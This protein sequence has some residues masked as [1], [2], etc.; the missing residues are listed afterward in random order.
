MNRAKFI[1]ILHEIENEL[2]ACYGFVKELSAIDCLNLSIEAETLAQAGQNR[3]TTLVY[4]DPAHDELQLGLYFQNDIMENLTLNNPTD[5]LT[6]S[7]LDA[8]CVVVEE[9]SHFHLW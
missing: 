4:Q 1:A 8:F 9:L 6:H 7:N 2:T 5:S 3:A